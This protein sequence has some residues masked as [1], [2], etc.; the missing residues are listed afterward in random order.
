MREFVHA[1]GRQEAF[2]TEAAGIQ[3]RS[4]V[5]R[6][7]RHHAAPE[8]DIHPALASCGCALRSVT[9]RRGGGGDAI[10]RHVDQRGHPADSRR[11]RRRGEAFPFRAARLVDVYMGIDQ[12]GQ[13]HK[14]ANVLVAR[15]VIFA[16]LLDDAIAHRDGRRAQAFRQDH[17]PAAYDPISG[18]HREIFA[19]SK[20]TSFST[21]PC[22]AEYPPRH[23][24]REPLERQIRLRKGLARRHSSHREIGPIAPAPLATYPDRTAR[25]LS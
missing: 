4:D 23:T 10:E 19:T 14:F 6:V 12:A 3:Q 18:S 21:P 13:H 9:F 11:A 1:G 22:A 20:R 7:P 17:A 5:P 2:E 15:A 8:S 16:D 24:L 25:E